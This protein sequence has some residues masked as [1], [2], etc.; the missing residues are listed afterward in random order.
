[1]P[2]WLNQAPTS[3]SYADTCAIHVN[4]PPLSPLSCMIDAGTQ[5]GNMSALMAYINAHSAALGVHVQFATAAEY[6]DAAY[7]AASGLS[8]STATAASGSSDASAASAS[9]GGGG[10][11]WPVVRSGEVD[12]L[13]GW[14]HRI[15][16]YNV[17]ETYQTGAQTSWPEYKALV[18]SSAALLRGA[19]GALAAVAGLIDINGSALA[20]ARRDLALVQVL[21]GGESRY[22]P[23][24]ELI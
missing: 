18:R 4:C 8:D 6:F 15:S 3:I 1:M 24:V 11:Q 23:I 20:D 7:K 9:K 21:R 10:W 5:F 13:V 2:M 17:S 16:G 19:E 22:F 14:P 12:F